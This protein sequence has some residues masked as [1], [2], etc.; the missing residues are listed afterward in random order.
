MAIYC[1]TLLATAFVACAD[2]PPPSSTNSSSSARIDSALASIT[3]AF[4]KA[5]ITF[6]GDDS[7]EGRGTGTRGYELAAKHVAATFESMGLEPAGDSG[8]FF[9]RVPLLESSIDEAGTIITLGPADRGQTLVLGRDFLTSGNPFELKTSVSAPLVFVGYGVDAPEQQHNDYAAVNVAGKIAVALFDAPKRFQSSARAHYSSGLVKRQT[10]VAH[11]AIGFLQIASPALLKLYPWELLSADAQREVLWLDQKGEPANTFRE[12]RVTGWLH[13]VAAQRLFGSATATAGVFARDAAG[14]PIESKDLNVAFAA[15]TA[16]RHRRF[17]S[18]NVA[19]IYRGAELRD[20]F[21]VYSAHLDHLGIGKPVNN[22]NIYNGVLDNASGVAGMLAV[23]NAFAALP[24]RPRRSVLFVAVTA[25]EMGLVGS[26]YYARNPTVPREA[27]VGNVNLDG[28]PLLYDFADVIAF[29]FEHSTIATSV[30]R[31][32]ER[33][34][35]AITPDPFPEQVFFVRSDHYSFVRL[36]V[37]AIFATEGMKAVDP[38]VNGRTLFDN[39]M[40]TRYHRPNDDLQQ[41]LNFTAATKGAQFQFLV[42][43][44]LATDEDVPR[45]NPGD[46]FGERFGRKR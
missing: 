37:P 21:V 25:E 4:V 26:D 18:T 15:R 5:H 40:A 38:T 24:E 44:H 10:A 2:D 8:G 36:G 12:L 13:E 1:V 3:P 16:T 23:A 30:R 28:L 22:D 39:W 34:H 35:L 32:A 46:F 14:Q 17:E 20:Q 7:L 27:I 41:P 29:G 19:A 11:G 42:G 9:Q 45:W 43:Y 33:L 31:A 6:L